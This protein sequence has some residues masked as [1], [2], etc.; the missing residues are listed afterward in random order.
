MKGK[1][2]LCLAMVGAFALGG[3]GKKEANTPRDL[4]SNLQ[5][6]ISKKDKDA[7]LTCFAADKT[8]TELLDAA[9]DNSTAAS[10]LH[11]ALVKEYGEDAVRRDTNSPFPIDKKWLDEL[12]IK[13][14]GNT[15][16]V[17]NKDQKQ[18]LELAKKDG[19][20]KIKE[21]WMWANPKVAEQLTKVMEAMADAARQAKA[22]IGKSG[23]SA[24]RIQKEID[25]A[26]SAAISD[27]TLQEM[28]KQ[29]SKDLE[30]WQKRGSDERLKKEV[31]VD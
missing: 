21:C 23:Y 9:F 3:C 5:D 16:T 29:A 26:L 2:I 25:E 15:A 18:L 30:D 10:D 31:K 11:D 20:W 4:M 22:N 17:S 1:L 7:F 6:S 28:K 8:R 13:E 24:Q 14:D 19:V 12:G 27:A